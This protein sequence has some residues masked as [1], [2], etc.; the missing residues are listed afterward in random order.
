MELKE[1]EELWDKSPSNYLY[2]VKVKAIFKRHL[3]ENS[4]QACICH[5]CLDNIIKGGICDPI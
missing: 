2:C 4:N 3:S 5:G 1:Y